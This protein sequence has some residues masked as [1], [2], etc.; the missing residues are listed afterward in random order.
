MSGVSDCCER[1][2]DEFLFRSPS[3][4]SSALQSIP[5]TA[6]CDT[7][8]CYISVNNNCSTG[9]SAL[10]LAKKMVELGECEAT[11]ALGFEKVSKSY[12]GDGGVADVFAPR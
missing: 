10:Y 2:S 11:M 4:S 8:S 5:P 12:H 6:S 9:S 1:G 3:L 7:D